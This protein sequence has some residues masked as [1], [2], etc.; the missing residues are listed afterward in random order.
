[1]L[2]KIEQSVAGTP[3]V[4]SFH[5]FRARTLGGKV[6]MDIHVQV[7]PGLTVHEGHDIASLVRRHVQQA[8]PSVLSVIVHVEPLEE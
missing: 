4:M 2:D 3:G 7:D 6:E 1:M 8:D 5:A